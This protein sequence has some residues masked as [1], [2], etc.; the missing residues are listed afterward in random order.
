MAEG[1]ASASP[2]QPMTVAEFLLYDDGTDTRYEL[3]DGIPVAMSP[4]AVTSSSPQTSSRRL[5]PS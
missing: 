4:P 2:A 1:A 5:R 3:V